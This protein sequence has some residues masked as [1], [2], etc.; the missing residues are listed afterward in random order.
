MSCMSLMAHFWDQVEQLLA[1]CSSPHAAPPPQP[2]A[3][4]PCNLRHAWASTLHA[5][6]LL[7]PHTAWY[8]AIALS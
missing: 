8:T 6:S 1:F 4:Q 5:G 7:K 3:C 2:G